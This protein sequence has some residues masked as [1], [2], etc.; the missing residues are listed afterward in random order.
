MNVK[1]FLSAYLL[2]VILFMNNS[3]AIES[4]K[5]IK[6][7]QNAIEALSSTHSF[8]YYDLHL[9]ENEKML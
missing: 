8:A 2:L 7:I 5:N 3:F 1:I 4:G 6:A 9:S